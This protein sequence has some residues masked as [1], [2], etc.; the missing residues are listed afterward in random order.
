[1]KKLALVLVLTAFGFMMANAQVTKKTNKETWFD[2]CHII[3]CTG[4]LACGD[5]TWTHTYWRNADGRMTKVQHKV[6][7]ELEG[8][9][10]VYTISQVTNDMW[11]G[12]PN[13]VGAAPNTYVVTCSYELGGMPVGVEHWTFH[14]TYNVNREL[15][16][17]V[18]NWFFE[19]Y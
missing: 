14:Y 2:F 12:D 15:T 1:M 17:V 7:G 11:W 4:D 9:L 16:T 18:D 5:L 19:C 13:Q 3:P 10:G 6:K 8:E